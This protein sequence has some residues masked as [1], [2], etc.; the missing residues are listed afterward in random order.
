MIND[1]NILRGFL[2][3]VFQGQKP[4]MFSSGNFQNYP[5]HG[6]VGRAPSYRFS[7]SEFVAR[8]VHQARC[9]PLKHSGKKILKMTIN[10]LVHRLTA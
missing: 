6:L 10:P 1:Y 8:D 2:G 7:E 3:T 4:A 5:P 9:Q